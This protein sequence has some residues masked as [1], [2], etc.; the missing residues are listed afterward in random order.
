MAQSNNTYAAQTA[1]TDE[2]TLVLHQLFDNMLVGLNQPDSSR[3]LLDMFGVDKLP[4]D[5]KTY[6]VADLLQDLGTDITEAG[7]KTKLV[8]QS[9]LK[10]TKS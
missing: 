6:P 4:G 5:A 1:R 9:T 7:R 3:S 8:I 2:S 10:N